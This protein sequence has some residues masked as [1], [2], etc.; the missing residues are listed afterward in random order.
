M[1]HLHICKHIIIYISDINDII[2]TPPSIA[3]DVCPPG[4]TPYWYGCY[5]LENAAKAVKTW[6]DAEDACVSEGGH[7]AS[8][9][10]E[11]ENSAFSIIMKTSNI[12]DMWIG[13]RLREVGAF[14]NSFHIKIYYI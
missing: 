10:A 3:P 8:I 1:Y 2:P 9:Q 4:Y 12:S 13:M 6:Q 14:S 7:L 11:S 5:K